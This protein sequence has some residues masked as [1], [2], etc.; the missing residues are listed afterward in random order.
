MLGTDPGIGRVLPKVCGVDLC[1]QFGY[2]EAPDE[3]VNYAGTESN[4]RDCWSRHGVTPP[5]RVFR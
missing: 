1:T 2:G 4:L 5:Y 3:F